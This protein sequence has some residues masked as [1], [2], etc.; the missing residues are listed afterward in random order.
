LF[1]D[2]DKAIDLYQ[3]SEKVSLEDLPVIPLWYV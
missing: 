2:L 3:Q 1:T